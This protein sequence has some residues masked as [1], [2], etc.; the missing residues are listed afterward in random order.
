M[1]AVLEASDSCG[2]DTVLEASDVM[3]ETTLMREQIK[4]DKAAHKRDMTYWCY[5]RGVSVSQALHERC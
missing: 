2:G 5:I 1:D 3:E 4:G